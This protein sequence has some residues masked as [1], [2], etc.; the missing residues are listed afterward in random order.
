MEKGTLS[1]LQLESVVYAWMKFE[2]RLAAGHRAGFFLGDGAGVGKGRQIAGLVYQHYRAGG[3][4]GTSRDTL[5]T[6]THTPHTPHQRTNA[7]TR[8]VYS[9]VLAPLESLRACVCVCVRAYA[10]VFTRRRFFLKP[11]TTNV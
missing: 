10:P 2:C 4:R 5:Y 6:H 8:K 9:L 3:R 7:P 1:S 11:L